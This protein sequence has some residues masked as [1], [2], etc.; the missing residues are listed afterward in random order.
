MIMPTSHGVVR[1]SGGNVYKMGAQEA[2]VGGVLGKERLRRE[3]VMFWNQARVL[4]HLGSV[5][6]LFTSGK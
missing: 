6:L 2:V 5:D 3:V 1:I 4:V